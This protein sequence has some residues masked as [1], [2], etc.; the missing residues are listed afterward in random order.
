MRLEFQVAKRTAYQFMEAVRV[1]RAIEQSAQMRTLPVTE[2]QC[3]WLA[4][5]QHHGKPLLASPKKLAQVWAEIVER[6]DPGLRRTRSI[7]RKVSGYQKT[8]L[9]RFLALWC[10]RFPRGESTEFRTLLN[11]LND[12]GGGRNR[13]N[14][15]RAP[16][17]ES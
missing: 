9:R 10:V 4:A 16:P 14:G 11:G 13:R 15:L 3:R 6:Y 5:A 2:S 17:F 7:G 12:L 1:C 8:C